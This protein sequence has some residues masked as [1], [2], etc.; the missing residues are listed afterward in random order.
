MRNEEN[1][2]FDFAKEPAVASRLKDPLGEQLAAFREFGKETRILETRSQA[3]DGRPL[4]APTYVNEFW[5]AKQR[6]A[7]RLHEISYRACFKPQLPRFFIERLTAPGEVVYDPFMGRG[8]SL[9]EAALLGRTPFGCDVNPLS[10]FLTRPR[11]HPPALREVGERLQEIDLADA[12]EQPE[13]LLVFYHP[14]TLRQIAALKKYL[15]RRKAESAL[16]AVDEW[17]WMVALNRLTGHSRGFFSVYTMP[18]NQAVSVKSQRKINEVRGQT[19]PPRNVREIICRKTRQLLA[20]CS[21][22]VRRRLAEAA[23]G[24]RILTGQCESTPEIGTGSVALAVTSPPFLNV[25]DYATDNWLRCWF[26]GADPRSV[27]LT[28]PRKLEEWRDEMACVLGELRRVLKAGG[29]V[30]FEVGEVRGGKVKL[31]ETVLACGFEAGLEPVLVLINDQK[32]TKT[33]NC[34]G[35]DNNFKGTNTN[36]VVVFR[37]PGPDRPRA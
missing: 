34:W 5:T 15:L 29:H 2:L 21:E 20:D 36:R 14:D 11:L 37:K 28:V 13:E 19:P 33:A 31:E 18:P 30:A 7:S 35:V 16:D 6:A 22:S 25:V 1:L 27:K 8:T 23:R 24:A 9:I 32:F 3:V 26:I 17:I 4:G 10:V 12:D